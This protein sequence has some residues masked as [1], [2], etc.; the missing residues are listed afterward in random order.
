MNRRWSRILVFWLLLAVDA[1]FSEVPAD[2]SLPSYASISLREVAM[3]LPEAPISVGIDVD[4]TVLF[5][6]HGYHYGLT[7]RDGPENANKYGEK[8]LSSEAFWRDMNAKFDK[9]SLPKKSGRR[10]VELHRKRGD[11][12]YFITSRHRSPNQQLAGVLKKIFG[13][14][15][16]PPVIF[17]DGKSKE[18]P[19]RRYGI[20]LFYGDSDADIRQAKSAGI[21]A[22]RVL[23]PRMSNNPSP[24]NPGKFQEPVLRDSAY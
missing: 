5:S 11:R 16:E 14:K 24:H 21:R 20:T 13:F 19:I 4:D 3:T 6:S 22:I 8:P 2:H 15:K 10:I 9:F 1:G 7:N 23:R 18:G 17:T 12:I